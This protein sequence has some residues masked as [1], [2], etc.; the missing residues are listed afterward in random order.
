MRV[1]HLDVRLTASCGEAK[2]SSGKPHAAIYL[3]HMSFKRTPL[4]YHMVYRNSR[5]CPRSYLQMRIFSCVVLPLVLPK[6]FSMGSAGSARSMPPT[7]K[8]QR[9][10]TFALPPR[11]RL[12]SCQSSAGLVTPPR[13][14]QLTIIERSTH[15]FAY[16]VLQTAFAMC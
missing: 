2:R 8:P 11:E 12:T 5:I 14:A 10:Y 3:L 7:K 13:H 6:R 1:S 16:G 9:T 15:P 4:D